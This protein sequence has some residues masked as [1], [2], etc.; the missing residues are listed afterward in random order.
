MG[1]LETTEYRKLVAANDY[2]GAKRYIERELRKW[3]QYKMVL[4]ARYSAFNPH[5]RYKPTLKKFTTTTKYGSAN[6]VR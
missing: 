2:E 4:R 3:W 6:T 1:I 5:K